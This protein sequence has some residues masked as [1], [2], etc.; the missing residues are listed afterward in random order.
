[1]EKKYTQFLN[2][3]PIL[4][5]NSIL[6]KGKY[7]R[8]EFQKVEKESDRAVVL[9]ENKLTIFHE[10]KS[11][12]YRILKRWMTKETEQLVDKVKE[13]YTE[14]LETPLIIRVAETTR[15]GYT[16]KNGVI[17]INSQLATLPSELSEYVIIHELIHLSK[18]NHQKK[19][20]YRLAQIFPNYKI[21]EKL[22]QE[23]V[24][25]KSINEIHFAP[26]G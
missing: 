4:K 24:S 7:H 20:R 17:V 5:A 25:I 21:A 8:L 22:L 1:M 12:P 6:Y 13:K 16:R 15:W 10:R 11:D 23:Y 9:E 3:K 14:I 26:I 18:M 19:F 2:R